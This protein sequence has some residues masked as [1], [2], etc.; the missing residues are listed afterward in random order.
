VIGQQEL[1]RLAM[2]WE[3]EASNSPISYR[4]AT[5]VKCA[6]PMVEMYHCWLAD[7][8]FRKEI[9][10][11]A[12]CGVDY[13]M[14]VPRTLVVVAAVDD[15][16]DDNVEQIKARSEEFVRMDT[17]AGGHPTGAFKK[18][19]LEQPWFES[20]LFLQ[21]SLK[22][23]EDDIVTP[24]KEEGHDVVAWGLFG[25][26]FDNGSQGI[27]VEDQY[28][29][30]IKPKAGIFGPIFYATNQAMRKS[31]PFWPKTPLERN[32]AQGTERAWAYCFAA[33]DIEV[34]TLGAW[35]NQYMAEGP[36]PVFRKTFAGRP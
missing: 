25:M 22:P 29:K 21:D 18:A 1:L 35:C 20:Y 10:L 16:F 24:F 27:W 4:K 26:N 12:R 31:Q 7:G 23:V 6:A 36:Y 33:A 5:C 19:F 9:H 15:A 17:S 13:E 30:D 2:Q 28:P 34:G 8:Y 11:C 32:Q 3:P 14:F